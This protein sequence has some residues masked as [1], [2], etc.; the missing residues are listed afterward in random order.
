LLLTFCQLR[1]F[2]RVRTLY[3]KYLE[4]GTLFPRSFRSLNFAQYDAANS[5]A[6]MKYAELESQL[7]DVAR[8]RAIFELGISQPTLS[9][10]ELLWKAY[11]DF[12]TAEGERELARAL[13]ERLVGLSGH[14]KVWIAYARFEAEAIPVPRD[15]RDEDE[16][17]EDAEPQLVAGDPAL[18]RVVYDRAYKDL[19]DKGLKEEVRFFYFEFYFS[20][21]FISALPSL[22]TGKPLSKNMEAKMIL[23]RSRR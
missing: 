5:T 16:E 13:Y 23:Q 1:E 9:M 3:E 8:A 7:G 15:Q 2:D 12:E 6:W 19:R 17:D 11:I 20:D 18:S 21:L 4:V 10:P 14:F 22:K